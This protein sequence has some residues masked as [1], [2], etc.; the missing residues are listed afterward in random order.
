MFLQLLTDRFAYLFFHCP[1]Q[2]PSA[3][4]GLDRSRCPSMIQSTHIGVSDRN[5]K[6]RDPREAVEKRDGPLSSTDERIRPR[7]TLQISKLSEPGEIRSRNAT[8]CQTPRD[9]R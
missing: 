5:H 7:V 9:T 3:G 4:H 6:P 8:Q 1:V 2:W